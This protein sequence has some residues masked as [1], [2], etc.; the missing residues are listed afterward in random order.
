M[1]HKTFMSNVSKASGLD[2]E[3][4][5]AFQESFRELL[6]SSLASG[7]TVSIPSFGNFEPRKRNERIMSHPSIKGKRLLVPPKLVA[8]FKPSTVLK[9]KINKVNE[10]GE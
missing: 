5:N 4:C 8:S 1:D 10:D 6:E 7:E 9:N 2:P 3:V